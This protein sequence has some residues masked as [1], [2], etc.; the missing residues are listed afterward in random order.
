MRTNPMR[1]TSGEA[2][3]PRPYWNPY[4]AG[5]VLGLVLLATFLVAGQGLGATALPKRLIAL[6]ASEVAP[7]WTAENPVTAS[8]VADGANPLR[9]WL[10]VEVVGVFLGGFLGA[11]SAGRFRSTVEKGPRIDVKGRLRW[12]LIGG[13]VMGFAAALARGCTSG[14]A[15]SGGA[16]LA[17]GSWAFMGMVF[18]GGYAFAYFVRRQWT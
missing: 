14:Q 8:Y 17:S 1:T 6:G 2:L 10:V 9:N 13:V 18:V 12:A 4:F 7:T 5:A 11:L 16:L 3:E 15:L